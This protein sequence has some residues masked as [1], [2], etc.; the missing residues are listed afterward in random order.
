MELAS[1]VHVLLDTD[2]VEYL[3]NGLF[4]FL[5]LKFCFIALFLLYR[6]CIC[7][8]PI[9]ISVWLHLLKPAKLSV[10]KLPLNMCYSAFQI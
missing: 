5:I 2:V 6:F 8:R 3:E 1:Q 7:W 10:L 4:W 9:V